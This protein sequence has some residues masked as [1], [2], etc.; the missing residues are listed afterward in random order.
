MPDPMDGP[1]GSVVPQP[2]TGSGT[3]PMD[4]TNGASTHWPG[5]DRNTSDRPNSPTRPAPVTVRWES[6]PDA[7]LLAAWNGVVLGTPGTDVT[8]LSAGR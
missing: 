1:V 2:R 3:D 4:G 6:A 7:E 8:Q 5:A